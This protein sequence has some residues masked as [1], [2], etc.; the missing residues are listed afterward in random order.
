MKN[1]ADLLFSSLGFDTS[2]AVRMFPVKTLEHNGIPF[3]SI[4]HRPGFEGSSQRYAHRAFFAW[5]AQ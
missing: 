2:T 4:A 1:A 5:S 3:A